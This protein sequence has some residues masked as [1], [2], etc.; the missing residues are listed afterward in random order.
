MRRRLVAVLLVLG[1]VFWVALPAV[2]VTGVAQCGGG[3]YMYTQGTATHWQRHTTPYGTVDFN[4]EGVATKQKS[5][6]FRTGSVSWEVIGYQLTSGNG[7][8]VQ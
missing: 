4:Y 3:G 5:W 8:C 6:G 7:F 1:L 2:A